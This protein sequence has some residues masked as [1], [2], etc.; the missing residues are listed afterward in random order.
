MDKVF[1]DNTVKMYLFFFI[2]FAGSIIIANIFN[3]IAK[4][5]RYLKMLRMG[6]IYIILTVGF[7]IGILFFD[8]GTDLYSHLKTASKIFYIL[9]ISW[10]LIDIL[11]IIVRRIIIQRTEEKSNVITNQITGLLQKVILITIGII[12]VAMALNAMGI[13][14]V[15]LV[16]GL[17]I[18]GLAVALAA[19]DLFSNIIGGITIFVSRIFQVED[20]VTVGDKDGFVIYIG[21]RTT[22][23]QMLNGRQVIIPN[24]KIMQGIVVNY[25]QGDKT[26]INYVIGLTYG[27]TVAEMRKAID[28]IKGV[29]ESDDRIEDK[30]IIKVGFYYFDNYSLNIYINFYVGKHSDMGGI[31]QDFHFRVKEE[32]DKEGLEIAFPTQTLFLKQDNKE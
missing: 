6:I 7:H 25:S 28:I 27:T 32:F 30:D 3:F 2:A 19:Q 26:L 12:A 23:L 13:N 9:S 8:S 22:Q 4:R 5:N 11:S 16:T 10:L 14:A 1:L 17:G 20:F 21:L 24:N 29:L 15:S 18:A 31:K